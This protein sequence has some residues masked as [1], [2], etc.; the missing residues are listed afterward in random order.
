MTRAARVTGL[1]SESTH[2]LIGAV[3]TAVRGIIRLEVQ[4]IIIV[5]ARDVRL[6]FLVLPPETSQLFLS[7][8]FLP[9]KCTRK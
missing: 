5:I 9:L 7:R 2:R 6:S 4:R 8:P 3:A 1:V